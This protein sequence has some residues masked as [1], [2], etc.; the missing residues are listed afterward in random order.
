MTNFLFDSLRL[1]GKIEPISCR[2]EMLS[3]L[4]VPPHRRGL[5]IPNELWDDIK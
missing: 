4:F 2:N 5:F 3:A 1:T